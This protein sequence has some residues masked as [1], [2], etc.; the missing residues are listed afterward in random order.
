VTRSS[1][2][3]A[4]LPLSSGSLNSISTARVT[5]VNGVKMMPGSSCSLAPMF[6]SG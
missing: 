1:E 6:V 2:I 3:S 4:T 5:A